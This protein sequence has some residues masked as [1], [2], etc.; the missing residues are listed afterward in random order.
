MKENIIIKK[1]LFTF[2]TITFGN[3]IMTTILKFF[4]GC[5][6]TV[7]WLVIATVLV[8]MKVKRALISATVDKIE[9]VRNRL[10]I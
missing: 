8:K 10:K 9:I 5:T 1:W 2:F 4:V 6:G 7:R 3:D